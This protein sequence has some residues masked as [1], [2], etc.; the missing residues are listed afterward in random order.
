MYE[1]IVQTLMVTPSG[2]FSPGPLTIAT[3]TIG[4]NGGWKKGFMVALGH[5][6]FEFPYVFA[7]AMTITAIKTLLEGFIGDILTI[8]GAMM[9]LFFAYLTLKDTLIT[10]A[11]NS[12]KKSDV[13]RYIKN[14][15]VVGFLFTGLNIHF[16]LWWIS[17]GFTLIAMSITIG[18]IG[19]VVMYVSHVWMDFLWLSLVAEASSRGLTI[20]GG[21][22]YRALMLFFGILLIIFAINILLKRFMAIAIIP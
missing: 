4:S 2:A 9:I 22:I 12:N 10:K 19:I 11:G 1:L 20:G 8:A 21:K 6:F 13:Y 3:M 17:I 18:I 15:I 5:T 16:L 7:I 14:P